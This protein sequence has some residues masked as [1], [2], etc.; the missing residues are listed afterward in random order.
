MTKQSRTIQSLKN[1]SAGFFSQI[2][3]SLFSLFTARI[4]KYNL[5]LEYL[6]INGVL[7]NILGVLSLAD[8]GMASAI[9]FS[10]YKPLAEKN[11]KQI[12]AL[13][14]FYN[15][16]YKIIAGVIL[17]LSLLLSPFIPNIVNS[18][19][20]LS[21]VY[22]IYALFVINTL[23][24]YFLSYKQCIL[25]SD[26]KNYIKTYYTTISLLLVR[27]LQFLSIYLF[28]NYLLYLISSIITTLALNI[29]LAY[30]VDKMY[31]FIKSKERIVLDDNTRKSLFK[32]IKAL[33][34]HSIGGKCVNSTDNMI[35]SPFLG[36]AIAGKYVSYYS[37]FS[38]LNSTITTIFSNLSASVGNFIVE[39]DNKKLYLIYKK[40]LTIENCIAI[41]VCSCFFTLINPFVECWLGNDA[42][43]PLNTIFL[44]TLNLFIQIKRNSIGV[45]T[46]AAGLFEFNQYAPL[47]ESAINLIISIIGVKFLGL[48]GVLLGT[49]ISCLLVPF[50]ITPNYVYRN[51]FNKSPLLFFINSLVVLLSTIF[52]TFLIYKIQKCIDTSLN[53]YTL[54]LRFI[55]SIF[56]SSIYIL[57]LYGKKLLSFYPKRG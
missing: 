42:L 2:I 11:T 44:I 56:I 24:S 45:I 46:G 36:I 55:L 23:S 15:K 31:S 13:L 10:L 18:T 3:L 54:V 37:I 27:I 41:F 1:I 34:F 19:L 14:Q 5:G 21:Y 20:P 43:L 53:W 40:M 30:K 12:I 50:W 35:I 22:I 38:L 48:N 57:I 28:D 16:A 52:I 47:V 7:G 6:G 33:F 49:I 51:I 32:K 25:T 4:M 29:F 17:V 9:G 26:Q 39:N 8:L